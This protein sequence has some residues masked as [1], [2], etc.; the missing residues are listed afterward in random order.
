[1]IQVFFNTDCSFGHTADSLFHNTRHRYDISVPRGYI[2]YKEISTCLTFI[3]FY[4][5]SNVTMS[6]MASQITNLMIVHSTIYSGT[7]QRK[8][9]SSTSLVFVRKIHRWPVNSPHEGPVMRKMFPFD[10]VIIANLFSHTQLF[11]WRSVEKHSRRI[12]V[13]KWTES[14]WHNQNKIMH[15]RTIFLMTSS[16]GNFFHVTGPLWGESIGTSG[17]PSQRPVTQSFDIFFDCAWTNVWANS[18]YTGDLKRSCFHH[19]VTAMFYCI[20][21]SY[22][23]HC[24]LQGFDLSD[25]KI[26]CIEE[27]AFSGLPNLRYLY[28]IN[29]G[30]RLT[31]T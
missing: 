24:Y 3:V 7:N 9:H 6:T 18:G 8:H 25:M 15:N 12:W 13:K 4:H 1:M 26:Y 27:M 20:Q 14:W 30:A 23:I 28:L 19:D 16:S 10:Y 17:F 5:Y 11:H 29:T 2:A 22:F 21:C 31:K